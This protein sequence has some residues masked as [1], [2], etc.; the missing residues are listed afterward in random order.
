MSTRMTGGS[1]KLSKDIL[2]LKKSNDKGIA[3]GFY[4]KRQ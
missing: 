2:F 1:K 4:N 3:T